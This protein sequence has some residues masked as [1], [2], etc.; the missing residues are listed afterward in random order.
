MA[1]ADDAGLFAPPQTPTFSCGAKWV[2]LPMNDAM[3]EHARGSEGRLRLNVAPA[4][5]RCERTPTTWPSLTSQS[6]VAH[7][8]RS[9]PIDAP[10]G[11][12]V[13][14]HFATLVVPIGTCVG[15]HAIYRQ[16]VVDEA[17][18]QRL[19]TEPA[20]NSWPCDSSASGRGVG[21]KGVRTRNARHPQLTP[22]LLRART[23]C[24]HCWV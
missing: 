23:W 2:K 8:A 7:T 17:T 1:H 4:C 11:S 24:P 12:K 20:R 22:S 15:C 21:G 16:Q 9:I 18:W 10:Y 6:V 19:T 14:R 13:H 3:A 5:A